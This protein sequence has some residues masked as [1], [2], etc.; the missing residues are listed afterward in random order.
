MCDSY[1]RSA[2]MNVGK[3]R[4]QRKQRLLFV[5]PT[6]AAVNATSILLSLNVSDSQRFFCFM[7]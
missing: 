3:E 2:I 7:M 1:S 4:G 5:S 6:A